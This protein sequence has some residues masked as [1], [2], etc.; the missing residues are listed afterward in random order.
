MTKAGYLVAFPKCRPLTVFGWVAML[1]LI[2]GPLLACSDGGLQRAEVSAP[3]GAG[4]GEDQQEQAAKTTSPDLR[5]YDVFLVLG[6]SNTHYGKGL[7]PERDRSPPNV[8]QLG[9]GGERDLKILPAAEPLDHVSKQPGR[10]GFALTFV[11]AY[12]AHE[13][14]HHR[15]ILLIPGGQ[16]ATSFLGGAWKKGG[17]L[18]EDAVFRANRVMAEYPGSRLK[19][20]L[21]HQG[22]SDYFNFYFK[23]DLDQFITS[24]RRD[25]AAA[26]ETTPFVLGGL[27]PRWVAQGDQTVKVSRL[28]RTIAEAME[29][30]PYVGYADPDHPEILKYDYQNELIHFDAAGQRMLGRRYFDAYLRALKNDLKPRPPEKVATL[31]AIGKDT[32]VSLAW[33]VPPSNHSPVKGFRLSFRKRG[34]EHWRTVAISA[35]SGSLQRHDIPSLVNGVTY[36]FRVAAVNDMGVGQLSD[37]V[38]ATTSKSYSRCVLHLAF[39]TPE[40]VSECGS[41]PVVPGSLFQVWSGEDGFEWYIAES[42]SEIGKIRTNLTLSGDYAKAIWFK[43]ESDLAHRKVWQLISSSPGTGTALLV[44][45]DG[46]LAAGHGARPDRIATAP[47]VIVKGRWYHAAVVYRHVDSHLELYLNGKLQSEGKVDP[48]AKS[49]LHIGGAVKWGFLGQIYD[50]RVYSGIA[51][52]ADD[53]HAIY[54]ETKSRELD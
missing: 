42:R 13:S 29:R 2:V 4:T 30:H 26:D 32:S 52:S 17:A 48:I 51:L 24:I 9:R 20:I 39:V 50:V 28:S 45:G 21:W 1:F 49:D 12:L 37:I 16:G 15:K 54:K 22:E 8:F 53:V 7:D 27:V 47:G 23:R 41:N 40:L 25:I 36:E 43:I 11:R 44:T 19:A 38:R 14:A 3:N 18:Y 35:D 33:F 31:R 34:E 6:Q 5:G 46:R 10:I